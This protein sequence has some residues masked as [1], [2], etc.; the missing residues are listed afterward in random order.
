[1]IEWREEGILL[2]VRTH[3]ESSAII[4]VLTEGHGR[5]A[6][7]VRGGASRKMTPVLQPGG[8][9]DL[10]WKARLNEHLGSFVVEPLRSRAANIMGDRLA[11]AG[12][13]AIS[14]LL[15]QTLP[16]REPHP[17]LY[18]RTLG[19]FDLFGNSDLWPLAY[20]R[21]EMALLE[22][23]GY[24]LDLSACAATGTNEDL[25]FISPKSGKAVSAQGAG[26]WASRMLDLPP[27]MRGEGEANGSE[28]LRALATTG[29]F[30]E[31]RVMF[32]LGKKDL[33]AARARL[34]AMI[35]QLP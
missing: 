31:N 27:V 26:E 12:L 30:L 11:L 5:H 6:G 34:V 15:C 28:I 4:D 25:C 2:A 32:A 22:E 24:G 29:Y 1:M 33:P 14:A 23:L 13:S 18:R 17:A 16:E 9:L 10:T 8:Q 35:G 19:L 3:G 20:L 21:W 7:V